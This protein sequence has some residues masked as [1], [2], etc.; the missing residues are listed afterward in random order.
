VESARQVPLKLETTKKRKRELEEAFRRV[1]PAAARSIPDE[2]P[3]SPKSIKPRR[4]LSVSD[5][6]ASPS[7]FSTPHIA[8]PT[9]ELSLGDLDPTVHM[10][11]PLKPQ[12]LNPLR[13][14]KV[15]IIHVKDNFS[16]EETTGEIILS[17]LL[18]YEREAQLGCEFVVSRK[19][20]SFLL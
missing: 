2:R 13:G 9:A 8:T 18:E 1:Y 16:D 15:V 14:L 6:M 11:F 19:G 7:P 5:G 3:V 17:E 4:S 20:E 10:S 12:S